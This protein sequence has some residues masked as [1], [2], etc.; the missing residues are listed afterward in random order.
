MALA[1][2][3]V[4]TRVAV[5]WSM[6]RPWSRTAIS[7]LS[8]TTRLDD[9]LLSHPSVALLFSPIKYGVSLLLLPSSAVAPW[10]SS[11]AP[12][13]PQRATPLASLVA[14][15]LVYCTLATA[16][17]GVSARP[18]NTDSP[19][20]AAALVGLEDLQGSVSCIPCMYLHDFPSSAFTWLMSGRSAVMVL[21]R[22][23]LDD[24]EGE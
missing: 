7:W 9:R 8:R 23:G 2:C 15:I 20:F 24:V 13:P 16:P 11:P 12:P 5:L 18:T 21:A 1:Y 19:A 3:I 17:P 14:G 10:S 6:T 22:Q 4:I